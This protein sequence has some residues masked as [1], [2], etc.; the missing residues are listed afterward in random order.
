MN[1]LSIYLFLFIVLSVA[2]ALY[3]TQVKNPVDK[4]IA[5]GEAEDN[6]R[7]PNNLYFDDD[8]PG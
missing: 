5:D 1:N 4:E 7:V 6:V 2:I 8:Y 3:V